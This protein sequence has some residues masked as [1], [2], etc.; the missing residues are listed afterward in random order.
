MTEQHFQVCQKPK[1]TKRSIISILLDYRDWNSTN[2]N[3]P[4]DTANKSYFPEHCFFF[5]Y[6]LVTLKAFK[7]L[8]QVDFKTVSSIFYSV[9]LE[10]KA[11]WS[12]QQ[13]HGI[14]IR[15]YLKLQRRNAW[16]I[17]N[18]TLN[19]HPT[20]NI[21]KKKKK[22]NHKCSNWYLTSSELEWKLSLQFWHGKIFLIFDF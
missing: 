22:R 21:T 19:Y 13:I 7:W 3:H 9:I 12:I 11:W 10:M 2:F 14:K 4:I 20:K 16:S 8:L 15:L 17:H 18:P 6:N 5:Q 1:L